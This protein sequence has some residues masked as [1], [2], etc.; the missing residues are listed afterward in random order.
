MVWSW[1]RDSCC[2][3]YERT[4][5]RECGSGDLDLLLVVDSRLHLK[6]V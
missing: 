1:G 4:S 6:S 3:R 2:G 5:R